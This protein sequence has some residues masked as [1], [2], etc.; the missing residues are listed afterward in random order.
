MSKGEKSSNNRDSSRARETVKSRIARDK[1]RLLFALEESKGIVSTACQM[2]G[3]SRKTA[4]EWKNSDEEF[5]AKWEDI[6]EVTLDNLESDAL[7]I[8]SGEMEGTRVSDQLNAIQFLLKTKGKHRGF[9]DKIETQ[10]S[11]ELKTQNTIEVVRAEF[12]ANGT[13][14]H[15]PLPPSWQANTGGQLPG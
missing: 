10:I 1:E 6:T 5:A 2:I 3:I 12:P 14:N 4:Y 7:K 13:E 9:S 8:A 11:G 15:P